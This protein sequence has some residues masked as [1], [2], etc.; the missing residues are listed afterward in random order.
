LLKVFCRIPADGD[1][2]L[3][4]MTPSDGELLQ[5]F[6]RDRAQDALTE[7]VRRHLNLVYSAALRQVRS[8]QLA[9]EV[10]Q[11]V[12]TD[13][14]RDVAKLSSG[15]GFQPVSSLTPWLHTVTGLS[16]AWASR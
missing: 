10:A 11:S 13:L 14:A 9:E 3:V 2:M 12:F 7:L 6:T 4:E 8:P 1:D 5:R 15:T 16:P